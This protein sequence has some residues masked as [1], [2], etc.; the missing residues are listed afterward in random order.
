[1]LDIFTGKQKTITR[2]SKYF[3]PDIDEEGK[4]IIAIY[5]DEKGHN[6]LHLLSAGNGE[7]VSKFLRKK[8]CFIPILNSIPTIKLLRRKKW[9][10]RNGV[11]DG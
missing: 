11:D 10:G 7:I 3:S 2:K 6:G 1:V 4:K 8:I 9:P 5:V